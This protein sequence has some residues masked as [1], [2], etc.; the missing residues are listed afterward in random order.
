MSV[1]FLSNSTAT[2][3]VSKR[4]SEQSTSMLHRKAFLHGYTGEGVDEFAVNDL[5]SEYQQYLG[6]T[7]EVKETDEEEGVICPCLFES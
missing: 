7:A 1:T 3:E 2:Q 4:V 6:A 5:V